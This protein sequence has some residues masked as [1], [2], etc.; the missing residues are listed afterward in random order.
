MPLQIVFTATFFLSVGMLLDPSFLVDEPLMV[1]TRHSADA[2]R[3][4]VPGH[5]WVL[6]DESAVD[7]A[8]VTHLLGKLGITGE[9]ADAL[10]GA[11]RQRADAPPAPA[12]RS[13]AGTSGSGAGSAPVDTGAPVRLVV[14]DPCE[15]APASASVWP[16]APGCEDC[17]REG[18]RWVHLRL[19]LTCGRVGCCDSS[20]GRHASA[21]AADTGHAVVRSLEPDET[22]AWCYVD[23]RLLATE[24]PDPAASASAL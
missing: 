24:D 9:T 17:L 14:V 3:L 5:V 23:E 8:L 7:Y 19:C 20:P 2:E 18:M 10:V 12:T 6:D 1:R 15:H 16:T 13:A 11:A 4:G 21:H 22:W